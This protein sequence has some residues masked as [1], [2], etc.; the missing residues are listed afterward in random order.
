MKEY[1]TKESKRTAQDQFI[2]LVEESR[3]AYRN[4]TY[5]KAN[6]LEWSLIE[7]L[8]AIN[9]NPR[10]HTLWSTWQ[11]SFTELSY[12]LVWYQE[13][14]GN[15]IQKEIFPFFEANFS[16]E[17]HTCVCAFNPE[18]ADRKFMTLNYFKISLCS[19]NPEDCDEHHAKFWADIQ[20][21]LINL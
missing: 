7:P 3:S 19:Q 16:N 9:T 12:L 1:L 18:T 6:H 2:S 15:K 5:D 10:L 11:G 21:K 13:E 4:E 8:L 17:R 14:I 20:T